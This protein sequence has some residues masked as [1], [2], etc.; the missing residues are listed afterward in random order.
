MLVSPRGA[1]KNGLGTGEFEHT[2]AYSSM[3]TPRSATYTLGAW[4]G[5]EVP[6]GGTSRKLSSS[7]NAIGHL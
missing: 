5:P 7:K 1:K 2:D 3:Q 4:E 6:R